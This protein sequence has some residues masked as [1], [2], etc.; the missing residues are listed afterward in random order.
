ML[1][2]LHMPVLDGFGVLEEL[3]ARD[4]NV[5]VIVL[6]ATNAA[7]PAVMSM[8]LGAFDYITKPFDEDHLLGAIERALPQDM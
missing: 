1:L 2:D 4:A 6:T 5:S 3:R 7:R 8:K